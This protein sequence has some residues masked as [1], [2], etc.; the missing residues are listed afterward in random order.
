MRA[1]FYKARQCVQ[2]AA[3]DVAKRNE[4]RQPELP[5]PKHKVRTRP[6]LRS[7][8]ARKHPNTPVHPASYARVRSRRY[9]G[10]DIA[11]VHLLISA[12]ALCARARIRVAATRRRPPRASTPL[13]PAT[14][15]IVAESS[16][17]SPS[18]SASTLSRAG[19]QLHRRSR[20]CRVGAPPP[21]HL[22]VCSC[23]AHLRMT[24]FGAKR[25][26]G[27]LAAG[28]SEGTSACGPRGP[29]RSAVSGGTCSARRAP[30][31]TAA[32]Q[33]RAARCA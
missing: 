1:P 26:Q 16:R 22:R 9:A 29:V 31:K 21:P 20:P 6:P 8:P 30:C 19:L 12:P 23:G 5:L 11:R 17:V 33:C 7:R 10:S 14:H 27:V 24:G 18:C 4:T 3:S 32:A 2:P 25:A 13:L 15:A 28:E